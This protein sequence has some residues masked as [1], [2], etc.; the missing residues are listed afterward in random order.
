[1]SMMRTRLAFVVLLLALPV[2]A[3]AQVGR[4][5]GIQGTAVLE[6]PGQASRILGTNDTFEQK[7]VI[8]VAQNSNSVLEFRDRTRV[9]LR[10]NTV[11]RVDSF[12]DADTAPKSM[13]LG[14]VKGGLRAVSGDIAKQG[15]TA[16]RIQT[17]TAILGV[18]GTE[19]D[20]RI[21]DADCAAEQAPKATPRN[22]PTVVARVISLS[23]SVS[24]LQGQGAS[25]ALVP[26]AA[27]YAQE[28]VSTG[29]GANT[30]LAFPDGTRITLPE[31]SVLAISRFEFD[32]DA[33]RQGVAHM[34]LVSGKAQVWTG[35]LAKTG[36]DQFQFETRAG[37]I[38]PYGTGF[39]VGGDEVVVIYTWDGTV[40]LQTATER[41][42][43]RQSNA[44]SVSLVDGKLTVTPGPS[45][46]FDTIMPRPDRVNV[47]P[48]TFGRQST[49]IEEGLYVWVRDGVVV[50][51]NLEV[52][53]GN[54]A[55]LT[56]SGAVLLDAVPNFMRFDPA[57]EP[58][59]TPRGFLLPFFRAPDGSI[60]N[61]CTGP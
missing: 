25:R 54:A 26:G 3:L 17:N 37:T 28:S 48:A 38:R 21:C 32:P 14:L 52:T 18:R 24:A 16:M 46:V 42:E 44:V 8:S 27:V 34:K 58:R 9:T 53:A 33:P 30:L 56:R 13:V 4:V 10:P 45:A 5:V 36:A 12:A 2:A 1:M 19:F 31:N 15:P 61:T 23:G 55:R 20:A 41:V 40:I 60:L 35:Q 50:L 6:R 11:F 47:D 29:P 7:D 51:D 57:P 22:A 49:H 43:V 39:G 59:S